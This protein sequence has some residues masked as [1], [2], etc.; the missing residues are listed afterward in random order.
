[1]K[2]CNKII[3]AFLI[4]SHSAHSV[5]CSSS[6]LAPWT[7]A[8]IIAFNQSQIDDTYREI[9]ELIQKLIRI[10]RRQECF[11]GEADK[12]LELL[13]KKYCFLIQNGKPIDL[14]FLEDIMRGTGWDEEWSGNIYSYQ[15]IILDSC[16]EDVYIEFAKHG[17]RTISWELLDM[18]SCKDKKD[19]DKYILPFTLRPKDMRLTAKDII[20]NTHLELIKFG[21][22]FALHD[23]EAQFGHN[24]ENIAKIYLAFMQRGGTINIEKIYELMDH[25][26]IAKT[27][28]IFIEY[29]HQNIQ[30]D[31]KRVMHKVEAILKAVAEKH[32]FSAHVTKEQKEDFK[33]ILKLHAAL[34]IQGFEIDNELLE[35]LLRKHGLEYPE[36]VE[37]YYS[38]LIK[39]NIDVD[40]RVLEDLVQFKENENYSKITDLLKAISSLYIELI[41]KDKVEKIRLNILET[42]VLEFEKNAEFN[43]YEPKRIEALGAVYRALL[44][45]GR[46][47]DYSLIERLKDYSE[48]VRSAK[49]EVLGQIYRGQILK[50]K[51]I[52]IAKLEQLISC[53]HAIEYLRDI[54]VGL[55]NRRYSRQTDHLPEGLIEYFIG[56]SLCRYGYPV[57]SFTFH[58]FSDWPLDDSS[59]ENIDGD[60]IFVLPFEVRMHVK[61]ANLLLRWYRTRDASRVGSFPGSSKSVRMKAGSFTLE[62][63]PGIEPPDPE[64]KQMPIVSQLI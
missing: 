37:K 51:N 8:D 27:M 16:L 64:Q 60:Q 43:D 55:I 23:L 25:I 52:S 1:M 26:G 39:N 17:C 46:E 21:R 24:N 53:E 63:V 6:Y 19:K 36:I 56:F 2:Y 3:I 62:L 50:G 29:I 61:S 57:L 44:I 59:N 49:A 41:K 10:F 13:K 28:D 31:V 32:F 20:F 18:L 7:G 9:D 4:F 45:S 58:Y 12:I 15:A 5:L 47:V 48:L 35:R 42:K 14:K 54:Y 30:I 40:L 33:A 34:I 38:T 11:Y 22:P